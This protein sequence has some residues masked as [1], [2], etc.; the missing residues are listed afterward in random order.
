VV[1]LIDNLLY[2][3]LVGKEMRLHTLPV[4]LAIVGGLLVFGASGIVLG[5]VTLAILLALLDILRRRT[6]AGR[7]AEQPT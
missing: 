5:P 1:G 7:P 6:V 4:F 2:P 3:V